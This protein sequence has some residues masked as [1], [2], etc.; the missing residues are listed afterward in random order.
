MKNL[1]A[2]GLFV[3]SFRAFSQ[4]GIGTVGALNQIHKDPAVKEFQGDY[5][6]LRDELGNLDEPRKTPKE[7]SPNEVQL[8]KAESRTKRP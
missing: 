3:F 5:D 4:G 7:K 2:L 6:K 1:L 8:E